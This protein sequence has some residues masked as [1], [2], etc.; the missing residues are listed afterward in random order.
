MVLPTAASH[1]GGGGRAAAVGLWRRVCWCAGWRL[2]IHSSCPTN[3]LCNRRLPQGAR[4]CPQLALPAWRPASRKWRPASQTMPLPMP[5]PH[6][7]LPD[8]AESV[9]HSPLASP[10]HSQP[11]NG[12]TQGHRPPAG[13]KRPGDDLPRLHRC[14]KAVAGPVRGCRRAGAAGPSP[15]ESNSIGRPLP[16]AAPSARWPV[17]WASSGWLPAST[18]RDG[19][20]SRW[21]SANGHSGGYGG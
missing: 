10:R 6:F 2:P 5:L 3:P 4:E 8:I 9:L 14:G 7:P 17:N 16:I 21:L 20:G 1:G 11:T 18:V 19:R 15:T 12:A 13:A